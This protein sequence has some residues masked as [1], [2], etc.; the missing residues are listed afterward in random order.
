MHRISISKPTK[1]IAV[2]ANLKG[3]T[4]NEQQAEKKTSNQVRKWITASSDREE[5]FETAWKKCFKCKC[6]AS[7]NAVAWNCEKTATDCV[8]NLLSIFL[9][10]SCVTSTPNTIWFQKKINSIVIIKKKKK[11]SLLTGKNMDLK[12]RTE[13]S[14]FQHLMHHQ[15]K[16]VRRQL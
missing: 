15:I 9:H 6:N 5:I 7:K 13:N 3:S 2:I 8:Q 1:M 14:H 4:K 11:D 10:S 16:K 12:K